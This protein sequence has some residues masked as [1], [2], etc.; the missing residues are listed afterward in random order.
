MSAFL[1]FTIIG[2]VTGAIYAIAATGLVV[3]YTSSGIFNIAHGAIGMMMAFTYW[4]LRVTRHWPALLALVVVLFIL[5]PLLG[6]VIERVL[7][8]RLRGATVA[9]SLVVTV[10]L[11]VM[12][13]GIAESIWSPT[14]G[15]QLP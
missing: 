13:L 14:K 10:G 9:Q 11:M 7:I 3:T 1:A 2:I 15:R 5:A 4:E 6:A 12:L 8:R